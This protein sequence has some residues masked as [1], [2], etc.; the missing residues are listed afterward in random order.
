M[1]QSGQRP[2]SAA[3]VQSNTPT[4]VNNIFELLAAAGNLKSFAAAAKAADLTEALS[5]KGRFTVFVPTDEAFL[6]LSPK[7]LEAL[8][9]DRARLKAVLNYHIVSGH[10]LTEDLKSGEM[11]TLQ[12][13][14]LKSGHLA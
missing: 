5:R 10:L 6:K 3:G 1:D 12:G 8:L 4:A 14:T 7:G 9:K 2:A 13:L 11:A